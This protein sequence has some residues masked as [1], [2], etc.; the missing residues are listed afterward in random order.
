MAQD[1]DENKRLKAILDH[2]RAAA[3]LAKE[4]ADAKQGLEAEL[5]PVTHAFREAARPPGLMQEISLAFNQLTAH[6]LDA[7]MHLRA[8]NEIHVQV[9]NAVNEAL[10]RVLRG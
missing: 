9:T 2:I 7:D 3:A 6:L 10:A 5:D 1:Y 8:D 4:Q